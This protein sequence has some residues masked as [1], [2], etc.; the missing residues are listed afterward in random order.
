M[1]NPMK[2]HVPDTTHA[3]GDL[4]IS[5]RSVCGRHIPVAECLGVTKL[6]HETI[7]KMSIPHV[8]TR[9]K[10]WDKL[11]DNYIDNPHTKGV[12]S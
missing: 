10:M 1:C 4:P 2:L 6:Q 8:P 5:G 9:H 12:V 7:V 11:W 3:T